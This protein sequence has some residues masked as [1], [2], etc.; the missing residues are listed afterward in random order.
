MHYKLIVLRI[1]SLKISLIFQQV[2]RFSVNS[3]L[4]WT[5]KSFFNE[6]QL[7]TAVFCSFHC[8]HHTILLLCY[9]TVESGLV[10]FVNH[11]WL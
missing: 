1:V 2:T 9:C 11:P 6:L 8:F 7:L 5:F 4:V 3:F 10:V